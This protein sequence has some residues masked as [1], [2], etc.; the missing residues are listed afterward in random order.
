MK[1]IIVIL[2]VF[3]LSIGL[4]SCRG[5]TNTGKEYTA[6]NPLVFRFA[7]VEATDSILHQ[8]A[9]K[10]KEQVEKESAGRVKVE[11]YPNGELGSIEQ[12]IEAV[13]AGM[14]QMTVAT[15]SSMEAYD[16]KL[17]LL[18]IPFLFESPEEMERAINGEVGEIY[19]KWLEEDGFYCAGFQYDGA[20]GISNSKH[21]IESVEDMKGLKIRVM[22]SNLY[23]N[24]FKALGANPTPMAF[25]ELYTGLQQGTV[26]GQDNSP[27]L[28]YVN[29]FY[30]VQDYYTS[31][32][33]VYANCIMLADKIYMDA[34]PKDIFNIIQKGADECLVKYQ[35]ENAFAME[36][37]YLEMMQEEGST[38]I[39]EIKDKEDWRKAA[40]P[41]Y[42]FLREEVGDKYVD[43]I[44]DAANKAKE[45]N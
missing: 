23:I 13:K 33:T 42:D 10:F 1:K 8:S 2:T 14:L 38:Q 32:G 31:I 26:D 24:L 19:S 30:E 36:E 44:L 17:V 12:A 41:V 4:C 3:V 45:N 15:T 20:R 28:T 22:Q 21:P 39:T 40:E 9:L 25:T 16:P 18:D 27:M 37:E 5:G 35:R 34:L 6:E 43:Q 29:K 7:H 11:I